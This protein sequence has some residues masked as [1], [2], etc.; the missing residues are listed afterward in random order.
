MSRLKL[1]DIPFLTFFDTK[2]PNLEFI[3]PQN[4]LIFFHQVFNVFLLKAHLYV[5]NSYT[6]NWLHITSFV[7]RLGSNWPHSSVFSISISLTQVGLMIAQV[8]TIFIPF[9]FLSEELSNTTS[10]ARSPYT[11]CLECGGKP[12]VALVIS[13]AAVQSFWQ[14]HFSLTFSLPSRIKLMIVTQDEACPIAAPSSH[15]PAHIPVAP[16]AR[17]SNWTM[18]FIPEHEIQRRL[19]SSF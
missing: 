7:E 8:L 14:F 6:I 4:V 19:N 10:R 17:H 3:L 2:N 11:G 15:R 1:W 12:V 9:C 16:F 18:S 5:R 13:R